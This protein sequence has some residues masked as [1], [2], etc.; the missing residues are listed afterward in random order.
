MGG[1]AVQIGLVLALVLVNAAL[2][3]SEIAL[4]SLREHR[5]KQ[6]EEEGAAGRA[7]ADLARDPNRFLATIQI[8]ITLAGFLASAAAATTLAKPLVEPLGFLGGAAEAVSVV[9]VTLILSYVTLVGGEL[10]PKR[11][12]LSRSEGW[13]RFMARP[14]LL[15][16]RAT[17]PVVWLLGRSTDLIARLVGVDPGDARDEVTD[18]EL[19]DMLVTH[20]GVTAAQR[21]II[22]G[23]FEIGE[24]TLRQVVVPRRD[25]VALQADEPTDQGARRLVEAGYS[26]APVVVGDLDDVVGV[27]HL[28]D[29]LSETSP[30]GTTHVAG[31]ILS[32]GGPAGAGAGAADVPVEDGVDVVRAHARAALILPETVPVIEALRRLQVERQQLAVVVNEYGGTEGIATMEDLVEELVGEIYSDTD[33]DLQAV[34]RQP[35]GSLLLPGTFP[36]HDLPDLGVE[37]PTGDYATVAGLVLA[38]LGHIPD[39]GERVQVEGWQ[40]EVLEVA[41]HAVQRVRIRPATRAGRR[42]A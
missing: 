19:R 22:S 8:G 34:L 40:V 15:M 36:V 35:D 37:L 38:E 28:R 10:A 31:R 21:G 25:V 12:A 27:V 6:M 32:A 4:I 24:R 1:I 3:G 13:A 14:L 33:R 16:S 9:V 17:R 20:R 29:L 18:E 2:S 30:T 42:G 23:A 11:I 7:V 26:R 39:L 41:R 5:L